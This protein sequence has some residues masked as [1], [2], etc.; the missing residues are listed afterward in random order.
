MLS[1]NHLTE[2]SAQTEP[3]WHG[4]GT[5]VG[6]QI[7]RIVVSVVLRYFSFLFVEITVIDISYNDS[8]VLIEIQGY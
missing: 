3:A 8:S 6:L 5:K 4:A 1:G 7:W 2:E